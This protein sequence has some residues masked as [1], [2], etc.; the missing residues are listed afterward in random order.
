MSTTTPDLHTSGGHGH[1]EHGEHNPNQQHHF[2]TMEQQ[3]DTS[4]IGMWL[5]LATEVL[6][7][8]AWDFQSGMDFLNGNFFRAALAGSN[9]SL[10]G[11]IRTRQLRADTHSVADRLRK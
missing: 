10:W 2:T 11:S 1:D 8:Q 4:K 7:D 9:R 6:G 3:F 5:F